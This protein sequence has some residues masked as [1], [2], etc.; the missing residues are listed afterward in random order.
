MT[1]E[2]RTTFE[3]YFVGMPQFAIRSENN[4]FACLQYRELISHAIDENDIVTPV[5]SE[6][7]YVG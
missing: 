7:R 4:L 6:W 3:R 2:F 5:F 1:V